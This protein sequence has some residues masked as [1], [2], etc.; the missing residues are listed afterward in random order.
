[1][2]IAPNHTLYVSN[3]N[4]RI[5]KNGLR[6]SLYGL[7]SQF[8]GVME[9]VAQRGPKKQGQA[10]VVFRD[11]PTASAALRGMQGFTFYGKPMRIQYS[12]NKSHVVQKELGT[13][14][15]TANQKLKESEPK[16]AKRGDDQEDGQPSK[17]SKQE[18]D[19]S[20]DEEKEPEEPEAPANS[21]L[22]VSNLPNETTE[23]MLAMLFNQFP[24]CKEV[25]LVPNRSD[26]AFIEYEDDTAAT[27]ARNALQGFKV[28]PQYAMKINY[29][30]K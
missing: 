1:M 14:G 16:R 29:A 11:I 27:V 4:N 20:S 2:D 15:K 10:F 13:F 23:A 5:R 7:F 12:L 6:R 21:I 24:G 3:L 9:I 30:K 17:K 19:E 8:G 18:K 22:Y 26:I 28:T 25:R